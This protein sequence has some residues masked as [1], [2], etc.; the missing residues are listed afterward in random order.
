MKLLTLIIA[1][2]LSS[3][4]GFAANTGVT[5]TPEVDVETAF[6]ASTF[7][8]KPDDLI[9][10]AKEVLGPDIG[11]GTLDDGAC[12]ADDFEFC[13]A[14]VG[15]IP[16]EDYLGALDTF[17]LQDSFDIESNYFG[18]T[19]DPMQTNRVWFMGRSIAQH[20][21]TFSGVKATGKELVLPPQQFHLDFNEE[22]LVKEIGFYTVD[23]RQGNT[24]GLGGAFG[25][26]YGVGKPLPIRE[27]QPFKPSKRYRFLQFIGNLAKK[28]QKKEE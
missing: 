25:Y 26:F 12:L 3:A 5:L 10:R 22:G 16:K 24:G 20:K 27:A 11:I 28:F 7:P 19:V 21:D 18:W 8:I 4:E 1:S 9:L 13:A 23:R 2:A 14:V 15:P 17:K 6:K